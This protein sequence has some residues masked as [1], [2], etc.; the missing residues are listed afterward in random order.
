[1]LEAL[2]LTVF[3]AS[4]T[5]APAAAPAVLPGNCAAPMVATADL[6][7][8]LPV[9]LA[10]LGDPIA[11]ADCTAQ[12]GGGSPVSCWGNSCSAE[13]RNCSIGQRGFVECDGVYTLCNPACPGSQCEEGTWRFLTGDCCPEVEG[14]AERTSQKCINGQW[15]TQNVFCGPSPSCPIN[16]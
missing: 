16:P 3:L 14:T 1:M 5:P 10:G 11:P 15:V 9:E 12:C 13:D 7:T 8:P 6:G 2:V 4:G